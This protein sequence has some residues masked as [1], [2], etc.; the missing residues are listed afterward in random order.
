MPKTTHTY[1]NHEVTIVWKPD[2]CIHSRICWTGLLEVFN[3]A[4]RPWVNMS[5]A[6]TQRIIEQVQKCP[7]GALS[8]FMNVEKEKS[9]DSDQTVQGKIEIQPNG[10]IIIVSDCHI[11]HSDGREEI[12]K[13]KVALCRC[14]SSSN[15]PYCDG[16][17]RT[18]NF[19]G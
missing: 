3:P 15:K 11:T 2:T 7:S 10:P 8:H 1:T 12:K 5:G 18:T 16:S 4:K 13:G 19:T 14:G 9:A 6:D 17:H